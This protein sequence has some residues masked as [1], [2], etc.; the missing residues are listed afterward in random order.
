MDWVQEGPERQ[1]LQ[2]GRCSRS[3]SG[4]SHTTNATDNIFALSLLKETVH[5]EQNVPTVMRCQLAE[6]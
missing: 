6:N 4:Q 1:S 2:E 5:E 3:C